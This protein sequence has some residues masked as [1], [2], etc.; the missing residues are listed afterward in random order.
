MIKLSVIGAGN[1]GA[2]CA[3]RLVEKNLGDVVLVDIIEGI[4]QG[5]ALDIYQSA[6]VEG[7]NSK[8]AGTNDFSEIKDSDIIV[9][10]AGLAR[11]PGMTRED[12]LKKN[13]AIITSVAENIKK[14]APN[15]I[16]VLVTNPLDIMCQLALK[17]TGFPAKRVVGMAGM[18]DSARLSAFI[19]METG[20]KPSEVKTMILGGHGDS[21]VAI[22]SQ[23][24]VKG[25]PI[26]EVLPKERIDAIVDRAMKGGAEIVKHL[27]TGSAFY[28]PS[29]GAAYMVE[30]ILKIRKRLFHVPVT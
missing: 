15:S 4:P 5:K 7:F 14:Y 20:C 8:I 30:Q 11:K 19:M 23:T 3:Q 6:S 24:T 27:K 12:L 2:T 21:M 10:T 25:K 22:V 16:V 26:S 13:A 28:A 1:V 18:L 17:V 29:A 9:V